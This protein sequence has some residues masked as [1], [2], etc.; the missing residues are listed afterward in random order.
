MS[1]IPIF[2]IDGLELGGWPNDIQVS[3]FE[4]GG[5]ELRTQDAQNGADDGVLV[6]RDYYGASTWS[7]GLYTDTHSYSDA[8]D[9]AGR[10]AAVWVG[11]R[12]RREPGAVLPL[13]YRMAGRWRRVYGRPRRY[14]PPDG[15]LLTMQGRAEMTADFLVVDHRYYADEE[16]SSDASLMPTT[17]GGFTVPFETPL[18]TETRAE[19]YAPGTFRVGGTAPTFPIVRVPG[20]VTD[21]WVE[22]EGPAG[23]WRLEFTGTIADGDVVEVDSRPWARNTT[24]NGTPVTGVLAL[25]ARLSD[26]EMPPG[27]YRLSFGGYGAGS[28]SQARITWRDAYYSL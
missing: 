28:A 9:A 8:L 25:S 16:Q 6:G 4:P 20:P 15:G 3:D 26:L 27:V 17:L 21:A 18:T 11:H 22:V 19:G 7:F 13:R 2:E 24:R 10:V 12:V 14:A 1:D 23:A 5:P